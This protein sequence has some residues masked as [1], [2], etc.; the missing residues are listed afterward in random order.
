MEEQTIT[1]D[2]IIKYLKL[3]NKQIKAIEKEN[4]KLNEKIKIH[5]TD[6]QLIRAQHKIEIDI[7]KTTIAYYKKKLDEQQKEIEHL[8][9]KLQNELNNNA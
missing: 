2:I 6:M 8:Q 5:N 1:F 7:K 3:M 9:N 4:N